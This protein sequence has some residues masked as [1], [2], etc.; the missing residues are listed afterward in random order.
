M[1]GQVVSHYRVIE[2]LGGGGMGVVYKAEDTTL[3]RFVALK[4]LPDDLAKDFQ[5]LSRFQREAQAASVL[6]HPNICMVFEISQ[7]EGRPFIA[8]EYLEGVTIKRQIAGKPLEIESLVTLSIEIADAL[9]AAHAEGIIHRDI[10]PT[11]IFI[12]KRGHAKI[13]DFGLAKHM[14]VELS[15][16]DATLSTDA[17][18]RMSDQQLTSPGTPLGTMAYMS[19]EQVRGQE[20]DA[21][22]DLFSFGVV[23]YEMATG[24]LPFRGETSGLITDAILHRLPVP[25]LRLNPDLP[26]DIEHIIRRALEKDRNLRYQH[27]ADMRAELQR[28]KRDL[29]SHIHGAAGVETLPS[30]ASQLTGIAPPEAADSLMKTPAPS[31]VAPSTS[32]AALQSSQ[33]SRE[34]LRPVEKFLAT[35]L[36]PIAGVIVERAASKARNPGELFDLLAS[37]L[38]SQKDRQAFLSRRDELLK[39]LAES[40]RAKEIAI[41]QGSSPSSTAT[42]P[43]DLT[44][45][46][47]RHAAELL[48]RY[49][50]PVAPVLAQRA[51]PRSDSLQ[52]LYLLLAGHLKN[53]SE[54]AQ[55]LH[56]AGFPES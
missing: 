30:A 1:I 47:I 29:S 2:K 37:S 32:T 11:N 18:P 26:Q 44:P 5:A 27:A 45:D 34:S 17:P 33:I 9:D 53:R 3:R 19:P 51:A 7:H 38:S 49:V 6:S 56:E 8:M 52:A 31:T 46:S 25:P 23:I 16:S 42:R 41:A 40:Q 13:L 10:K 20:L 35:L 21:R 54:R 55:F 24:T 12:T 4:F 36:G 43:A 22:S 48:A 50:G 28:I 14:R 15:A 39:A